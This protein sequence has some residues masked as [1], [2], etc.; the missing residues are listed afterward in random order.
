MKNAPF[1]ASLRARG[2][3]QEDLARRIGSSRA[4]VCLVLNGVTG[5]GF[6]TRKKLAPHLTARELEL[7]GWNARG[8]VFHVEC[9][10]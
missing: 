8:E 10:K 2:M 1:I 5:R 7:L 3:R 4:H 9:S 6:Q